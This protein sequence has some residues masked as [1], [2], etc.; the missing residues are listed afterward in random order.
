MM[1]YIAIAS[2]LFTAFAANSPAMAQI[3]V[4]CY[5]TEGCGHINPGFTRCAIGPDYM[6]KKRCVNQGYGCLGTSS[7]DPK[8]K[9]DEQLAAKMC[10]P[11]SSTLAG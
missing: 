8:L 5:S 2:A 6:G 10:T 7:T 9:K 4:R 3:C 11:A 1:K